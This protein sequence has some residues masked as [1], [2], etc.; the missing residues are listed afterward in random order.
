[1]ARRAEYVH[2]DP[3]GVVRRV[4]FTDERLRDLDPPH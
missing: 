4:M 2:I 3:A 1:M